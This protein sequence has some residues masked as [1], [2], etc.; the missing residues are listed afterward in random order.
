T[1]QFSSLP[2]HD[3]LPIS[4]NSS[5]R[6]SWHKTRILKAFPWS[7]MEALGE[8]T[9]NGLILRISQSASGKKAIEPYCPD[10]QVS[11]TTLTGCLSRSEEH[12]S[13]L[14]SRENLV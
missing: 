9:T 10:N 13:E 2:L 3:A 8:N 6:F 1:P 7:M 5:R 14:Q 12:T 4:Y 11:G